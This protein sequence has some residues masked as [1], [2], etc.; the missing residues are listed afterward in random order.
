[1]LSCLRQRIES[2]KLQAK[3]S[4]KSNLKA[5]NLKISD[6]KKSFGQ[7]ESGLHTFCDA[8]S[9]TYAVIQSVN[10]HQSIILQQRNVLCSISSKI[11][12][13]STVTTVYR[14]NQS[15]I[16]FI[17]SSFSTNLGPD[18]LRGAIHDVQRSATFPSRHSGLKLNS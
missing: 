5:A 11:V 8:S 15:F 3:D 17:T 2:L 7:N 10:L 6:P 4:T 13:Y 18:L 12:G 9:H 14:S 16:T 1:M